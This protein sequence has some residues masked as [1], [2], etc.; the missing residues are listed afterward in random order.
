[1]NFHHIF[2]HIGYKSS[3]E[4]D[5]LESGSVILSG[6]EKQTPCFMKDKAS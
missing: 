5:L 2:D 6:R 3:V 1:M 4:A